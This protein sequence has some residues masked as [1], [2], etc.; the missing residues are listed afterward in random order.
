MYIYKVF[1]LIWQHG[2][3]EL[4]IFL[5]KRNNFHPSINF[6][7]GY[8]REEVNY[9]DMQVIVREGKL[10]TD[11]YVKET[12][13]H[14]YLDPSS[15]HPYHCTKSTPYSQ[16]LRINWICSENTFFY[17]R[18]NE[19]EEWLIK[20][21][22]NPAVV[23]KQILKAR[24]FSRDTLLDRVKE[25][26]NDDRLVL[27]LTYH[28]SIKNFKNVL[29]EPHIVLTPKKE[30][31]KVFGGNPSMIG[32]RKLKSFKNHLLNAKIKCEL[33]SD[34]KSAPCCRSRCRI[35]PFIEEINTF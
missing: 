18:C 34:N 25:M 8:C 32:W 26:K 12:D 7:C 27:T 30:N 9:L 16:A 1:F 33:S 21:N 22:Y 20:R 2:E 11:L 24:A 15:C 35:C 4:K 31:R 10:I 3:D 23:R 13:S 14:Q 6:T 19:L 17:L 5:E 29:N 28:S